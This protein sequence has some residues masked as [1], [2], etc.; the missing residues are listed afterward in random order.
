MATTVQNTIDFA[1]AFIQYGPLAVGTGNQPALG[2]ANEI[3]NTVFNAPFIWGFNRKEN[4]TLNTVAGTQDYV[5]ALTDF[6]F[7]E[8]VSLTDGNGEVFEVL[9]VYNTAALG[10]G[11]ATVNKQ[12]RPNSVCVLAVTY[13]TNVTLRFMGVPNAIYNVTLTYQK[14]VTPLSALTGASGTWAIPDQYL[15]IYNNLF[16]GEAMAVVDDARAVQY[17]QRG[18]AALLAKAEGLT[19]LQKN[20]FLDQFWARDSQQ[21]ARSLRMQ[22]GAQARGV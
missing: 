4:S 8:K 16:V 21:Q 6:S 20:M 22:Q 11:N 15:D 17:R 10:K 9:D 2:I 13:G 14:L 18:I 19:E 12:Q 3:Q 1:S 5:V 7:L